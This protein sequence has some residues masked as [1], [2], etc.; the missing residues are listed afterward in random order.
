MEKLNTLLQDYKNWLLNMYDLKEYESD[1]KSFK[2]L[3]ERLVREWKIDYWSEWWRNTP[4]YYESS[5]C[6]QRIVNDIEKLIIHLSVIDNPIEY[7]CS[8]LK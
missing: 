8:I 1:W 5:E 4:Y 6:W 3:A 2:E 7:L